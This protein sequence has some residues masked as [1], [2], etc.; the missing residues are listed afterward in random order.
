MPLT[1]TALLAEALADAG[2][3]IHVAYTQVLQADSGATRMPRGA[4]QVH[5]AAGNL[6][7]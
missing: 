7:A 3:V 5:A 4:A 6:H 2:A 1:L